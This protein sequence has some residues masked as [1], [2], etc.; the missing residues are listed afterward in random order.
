MG[1]DPNAGQVIEKEHW[2]IKLMKGAAKAG[3][4]IKALTNR[5]KRTDWLLDG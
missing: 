5:T 2:F 4:K 1:E 3:L